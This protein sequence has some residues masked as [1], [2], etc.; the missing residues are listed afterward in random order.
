MTGTA[1]DGKGMVTI[2]ENRAINVNAGL[3]PMDR[4]R[5]LKGEPIAIVGYG[6]SLNKTWE[7]L[8]E[9]KTIWTVSKAHDFL[10]ERGIIPTYHL[11]LDPRVHKAEFMSKPQ[12]ATRYFLSSHV[13]PSYPEKLKAAGVNAQMFHVAID[14]N[15]KLD[16]RYPGMKVRFDA[17]IQAAEAAFLRGYRNQHWFGIEYGHAGSDTHAGMHWGV[18]AQRCIVEAGGRRFFSSNLFFHGLMLAENFL[19]DRALVKCTLHGDG[20]LGHFMRERGKA[21]FTLKV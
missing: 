3:P 18:V 9:F 19:C 6:P 14:K 20:L 4:D 12:K 8:R 17:G 13:H 7:R 11:D 1:I 5:E 2:R 10:V 16:P 15:E 21:K